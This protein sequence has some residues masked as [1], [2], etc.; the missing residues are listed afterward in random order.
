MA[1]PSTVEQK[2][3]ELA[4]SISK[5]NIEE[6]V[7]PKAAGS[8]NFESSRQLFQTVL[9]F[10]SDVA[11]SNLRYVPS[12][13]LHEA[14]QHATGVI[15]AI[16][17]VQAFDFRRGDPNQASNNVVSTLEESW[18]QAYNHLCA[19]LALAHV[20]SG[21]IAEAIKSLKET[22]DTIQSQWRNALEG[23]EHKT[24]AI[25][26]Q[27]KRRIEEL[28]KVTSAAREASVIGAVSSQAS[29]FEEEA[30]SLLRP[31]QRRPNALEPT[32]AAPWASG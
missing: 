6:L 2:L 20:S 7:H 31:L 32:T 21:A 18:N 17:R 19:H 22:A 23:Y 5:S 27:F 29:E 24:T 14:L 25:D 8:F 10:Y 30:I 13:L 3:V 26:E 16:S 9:G 28:E 4:L 1:E 11:S 12:H 15:S